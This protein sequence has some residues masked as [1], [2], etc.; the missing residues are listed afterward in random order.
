MMQSVDARKTMQTDAR[1]IPVGIQYVNITMTVTFGWVLDDEHSINFRFLKC[2]LKII[3][4][5]K[6][7]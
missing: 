3:K 6:T 1:K 5:T 7:K 4:Y 2:I